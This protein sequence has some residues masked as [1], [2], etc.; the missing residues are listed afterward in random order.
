MYVLN[1]ISLYFY[2]RVESC[3]VSKISLV[4]LKLFPETGSPS[5]NFFVVKKLLKNVNYTPPPRIYAE[6]YIVFV[7][8]FVRSSVR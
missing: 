8:P 2:N 4:S 6:R 1:L 7:F 3:Y 5:H